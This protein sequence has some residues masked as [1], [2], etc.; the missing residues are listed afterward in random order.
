MFR[1]ASASLSLAALSAAALSAAPLSAAALSAAALLAAAF[2]LADFCFAT[3]S[4]AAFWRA[5]S[6][7]IS[8][9]DM[10][11]F[12]LCS[13]RA[14]FSSPDLAAAFASSPAAA[15]ALQATWTSVSDVMMVH[16]RARAMVGAHPPGR[17]QPLLPRLYL[18]GEGQG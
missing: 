13:C 5:S 18:A 10:F 6:A 17:H 4:A 1:S 2:S 7:R 9:I 12:R 16:F 15:S 8:C 3:L 14:S 11:A